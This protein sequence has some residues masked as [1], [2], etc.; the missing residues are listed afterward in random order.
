MKVLVYGSGGRITAWL[1]TYADSQHVD[2]VYF[3]PGN[4][5]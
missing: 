5:V 3:T 4:P 1:D 2:K